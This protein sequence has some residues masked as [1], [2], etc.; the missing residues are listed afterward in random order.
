[1]LMRSAEPVGSPT[2]GK[3]NHRVRRYWDSEPCGTAPAITQRFEPHTPGWFEQVDSHR[4]SIEPHIPFFAEF[5]RYRG[6]RI[7]EIG[8][9]AG[10]DHLQWAK[11][12]AE[13]HGV[14]LSPVSVETTRL[15][16]ALYGLAS[17]LQ[18]LDAEN[19]NHPDDW[20]DVVYSWGVIHHSEHPSQIVDQVWRVLKPGGQF[21]G[22]MYGRYSLVALKLWVRCALLHLKPWRSLRD[23]LWN[24]MESIG[25]KAYT[26]SEL[27]RMFSRFRQATITPI[28]TAYDRKWIPK[29]FHPLL[30]EW[31]AWNL[32]IRALK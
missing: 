11:A 22:M 32:A 26:Q 6:S 10:A 7:L 8:V 20:F 23:V 18:C 17:Q 4:Y 12:G 28:L 25:T 9:G 13:C 24:H 3:L 31:A 2:A 21:I 15:H 14:D 19:L 1:M 30:P 27:R 16:L 5:G 29:P